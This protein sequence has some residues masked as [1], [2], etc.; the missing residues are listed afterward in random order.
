MG[1][2]END[3]SKTWE[4]L[5]HIPLDDRSNVFLPGIGTSKLV[6]ELLNRNVKL[7]LNDISKQALARVRTRI[8]HPGNHTWLQQDISDPIQAPLP[9]IDLWID[10]AVLHFLISEAAIS[11]YFK[12]LHGM[13]QPGGYVLFVE[14]SIKGATQCAGLQVQRY[15][16]KDLAHRLG[17]AYKEITSFDHIYMTPGG[18]SK[19]YLYALFKRNA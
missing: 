10:R 6:E 14:F 18:D 16:V 15:S 7:V 2:W 3:T 11:G 12:N 17:P 1:W 13:V 5:N 8:Q 4:L 9:N 19:P